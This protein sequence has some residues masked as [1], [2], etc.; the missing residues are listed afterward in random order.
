MDLISF[1]ETQ[2]QKKRIQISSSITQHPLTTH[3]LALIC[4]LHI[5]SSMESAMLQA[6]L[7]GNGCSC[8]GSKLCTAD[9]S[10]SGAAHTC[11]G[12]GK[13]G[14]MTGA[15]THNKHRTAAPMSAS[16]CTRHLQVDSQRSATLLCLN[17][18]YPALDSRRTADGT[19]RCSTVS[20]CACN[21]TAVNPIFSFTA[22]H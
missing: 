15:E 9:S 13:G 4:G 1:R 11:F 21:C 22:I 20:C 17:P 14:G 18:L 10:W 6:S 12:G 3:Q 2:S 5:N 16:N 8:A 19:A 7:A